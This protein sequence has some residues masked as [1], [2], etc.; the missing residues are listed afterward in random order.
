M[1]LLLTAR[2]AWR[3]ISFRMFQPMRVL[4]FPYRFVCNPLYVLAVLLNWNDPIPGIGDSVVLDYGPESAQHFHWQRI[5]EGGFI[6]GY[7]GYEW[8]FSPW[9]VAMNDKSLMREMREEGLLKDK[10]SALAA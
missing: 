6:V 2:W 5:A 7:R 10:Q 4:L 3:R 9:R 8:T 1:D